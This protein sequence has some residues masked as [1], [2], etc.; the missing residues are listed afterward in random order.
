MIA[1]RMDDLRSKAKAFY[2]ALDFDR[3]INFG[4]DHLVEPEQALPSSLY[5]ESIHGGN[6]DPIAE[7]ADRID[8][9]HSAG[10]YLFTGN[11]ATG[12]TTE[13]MRLAKSLTGLHDPALLAGARGRARIAVRRRPNLRAAERARVRVLSRSRQG[14]GAHRCRLEQAGCDR[15]Q[16]LSSG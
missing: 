2:N 15:P 1:H 7:L 10:A 9:S 8:F 16:A 4:L 3:P 6:R 5:V 11:R 13:L 12:K 14:A